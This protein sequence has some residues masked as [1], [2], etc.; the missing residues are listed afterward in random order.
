MVIF[1][2][3]KKLDSI[4]GNKATVVVQPPV[5]NLTMEKHIPI[6]QLQEMLMAAR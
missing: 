4:E 6:I 3:L 2:M 5:A 1:L